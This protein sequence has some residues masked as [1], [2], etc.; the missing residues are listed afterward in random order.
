ML[1]HTSFETSVPFDFLLQLAKE[2][3]AGPDRAEAYAE[4]IDGVVSNRGGLPSVADMIGGLDLGP[5]TRNRLVLKAAKERQ[6]IEILHPGASVEN[7]RWLRAQSAPEYLEAN[8]MG[9]LGALDGGAANRPP[10]N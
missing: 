7:L 3:P 5:E 10:S 4:L 8:A 9:V 2:L 1:G 6:H